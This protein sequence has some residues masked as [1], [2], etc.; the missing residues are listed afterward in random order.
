M[1]KSSQKTR[2]EKASSQR[3]REEFAAL[4]KRA[5]EEPAAA[6]RREHIT[7]VDISHKES[8]YEPL[9]FAIESALA[10]VYEERNQLIIDD[11]AERALRVAIARF[12]GD[13]D[14]RS[15]SPDVDAMADRVMLH[16]ERFF[17]RHPLISRAEIIGCLRRIIDSISTWHTPENPRAYFDFVTDYVVR[18]EPQ[19]AP[20]TASPLWVPGQK[21]PDERDEREEEARHRR[22]SGLWIP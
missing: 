4:Q 19:E 13:R 22:P 11:E 5:A 1:S 16:I 8:E 21:P 7:P 2:K 18:H 10:E 14:R 12:E 20:A 6:P 17:R 15:G 9:L 3:A